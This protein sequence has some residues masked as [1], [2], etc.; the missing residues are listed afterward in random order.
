[1]DPSTIHEEAGLNPISLAYWV[2]DPWA[3]Y[4]VADTTQIL[5]GPGQ[6]H[7]VGLKLLL[8]IGP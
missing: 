8:Q 2:K 6:G 7:G 1:M 3:V 5:H 4:Y